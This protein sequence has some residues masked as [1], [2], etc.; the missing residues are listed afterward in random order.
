M[1]ISQT[2]KNRFFGQSSDFER[3]QPLQKW[4]YMEIWKK[5]IFGIRVY[6]F[7]RPEI[8]IYGWKC[9]VI[10]AFRLKE[11]FWLHW[12]AFWRFQNFDFEKCLQKMAKKCRK[13]RKIT[14]FEFWINQPIWPILMIGKLG[15]MSI[16]F[17]RTNPRYWTN[18]PHIRQKIAFF[19][20]KCH[21]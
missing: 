16:T 19:E 10:H 3:F 15:K 12:G 20:V 13:I 6:S 7:I 1:T 4:S 18:N 17:F 21:F 2:L 8:L 14:N 5:A 11:W 9:I